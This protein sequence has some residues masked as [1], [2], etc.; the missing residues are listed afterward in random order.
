MQ[1][2]KTVQLRQTKNYNCGAKDLPI[3]EEDDSLR[4]ETFQR[5]RHCQ[6]GTLSKRLDK[7]W[8]EVE[9]DSDPTVSILRRNRIYLGKMLENQETGMNT[10][11]KAPEL[12]VSERDWYLAVLQN[13][14]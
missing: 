2:A 14:V 6:K 8:Y 11:Q 9:T 7:R 13:A 4:F 10:P 5:T 12:I 1:L 3:L